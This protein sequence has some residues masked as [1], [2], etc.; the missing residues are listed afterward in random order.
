MWQPGWEGSLGENGYVYMYGCMPSLFI[1][2]YHNIVD[3]LYC[4]TILKVQKKKKKNCLWRSCYREGHGERPQGDHT[5]PAGTF[6]FLQEN[7]LRVRRGGWT[8]PVSPPDSVVKGAS[9]RFHSTLG[10]TRNHSPECKPPVL[11]DI[12]NLEQETTVTHTL[13]SLSLTPCSLGR[14]TERLQNMEMVLLAQVCAKPHTPDDHRSGEGIL[15]LN[16]LK[17]NP[18][19]PRRLCSPNIMYVNANS[20]GLQ[21][22]S[23]NRINAGIFRSKKLDR[24]SDGQFWV[25]VWLGQSPVIQPN[26]HLDVAGNVFCGCGSHPSSELLET[27]P[28]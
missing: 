27:R 11:Q 4:N 17:R 26:T 20:S 22:A 24:Y 9:C 2:N 13:T 19:F 18:L 12:G 14:G 8:S 6:I 1:W 23:N 5:P 25:S 7:Y 21:K 15:Q 28:P 3:W 16:I 10:Q